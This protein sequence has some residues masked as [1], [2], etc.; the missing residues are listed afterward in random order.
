MQLVDKIYIII[1][2]QM[3]GIKKYLMEIKLVRQIF[4]GIKYFGINFA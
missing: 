4:G 1:A 3:G 2:L